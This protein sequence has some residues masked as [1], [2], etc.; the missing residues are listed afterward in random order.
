[1]FCSKGGLLRPPLAVTVHPD[2]SAERASDAITSPLVI[3]QGA[4]LHQEIPVLV[5]GWEM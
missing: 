5:R 3:L 4:F 1:M 2:S